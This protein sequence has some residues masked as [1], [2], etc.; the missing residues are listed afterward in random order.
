MKLYICGN[1]FDLHHG[2][3]TSYQDYKK[4]LEG[5]HLDI[6]VDFEYIVKQNDDRVVSWSSIEESLKINYVKMLLR[7]ADLDSS[8]E[9]FKQYYDPNYLHVHNNLEDTFKRLTSFITNFTGKFLLDWLRSID[10]S[11]AVPNLDLTNEDMYVCFNYTSTLQ[12]VYGIHKENILYIHG[13]LDN[14][15][16]IDRQVEEVR[17]EEIKEMSKEIGYK[18]ASKYWKMVEGP[19]Y[20]S[21]LIRSELKFGA[22]IDKKSEIEKLKHQYSGDG[23]FNDFLTPSIRVIEEYIDKSTKSLSENYRRLMSFV[24][25][26]NIDTVVIMGHSLLSVDYPYYKHIILPLLKNKYWIF[27]SYNGD[28]AEIE[29]FVKIAGI[30]Q[31][32]IEKW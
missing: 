4:Y 2:L 18:E 22:V 11:K 15:Q 20:Y 19:S 27:K 13:A 32:E 29:K 6:I 16:D 8:Y 9:N 21:L 1:G 3:K 31:Y 14:L 25:Q 24:A 30:S 5:E 7:Y 23:E 10:V 17:K 26:K 28:I 12:H